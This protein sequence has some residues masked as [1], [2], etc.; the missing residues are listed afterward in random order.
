LTEPGLLCTCRGD[1]EWRKP[2]QADFPVVF[3]LMKISRRIKDIPRRT[4][5]TGS[6][7]WFPQIN[8]F[9]Y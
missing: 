6:L 1:E 8:N 7:I 4:L 9:Q 5:N 3:L 2:M